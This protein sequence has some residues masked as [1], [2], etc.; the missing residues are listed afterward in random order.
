MLHHRRRAGDK[1]LHLA[2]DQVGQRTGRALV[3]HVGHLDASRA[4]E[5][6]ADQV[7]HRAVAGRTQIDCVRVGLGVGDKLGK[8]FN[9]QLGVDHQ[10]KRQRG[11]GR[12]RRQIFQGIEGQALVEPGVDAM[13]A[14]IAHQ[15]CVAIGRG[16]GDR[17]GADSAARTGAVLHHHLLVPAFAQLLRHDARQRVGRPARCLRHD[18]AHLLRWKAGALGKSRR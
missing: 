14:G 15:P 17:V 5:H 7:I 9:W 16:F 6:L 3:R 8:V 10:K 11:E 4:V 18:D 1:R 2:A 12:D 13:G